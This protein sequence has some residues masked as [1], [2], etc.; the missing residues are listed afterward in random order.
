MSVPPETVLPS[1]PEEFQAPSSEERQWA[2][3]AH[4]CALLGGL[5]TSAAGGWGCF[6]GPLIIYLVKKDRSPFVAE[7]ARQALNFNI[8]VAL[9]LVAL[10]LLSIATLGI[11]LI[12]AIPL[13]VVVGVGWLVLAI[14]ASVKA[15]NG[16][17]YRYPLTLRLVS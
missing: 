10:I 3:F 12:I 8:T 2:M 7:Q 5:L 9:V 1:P 15:N 6:V 13:W 4:L 17:R 14:I 11:G 16:E